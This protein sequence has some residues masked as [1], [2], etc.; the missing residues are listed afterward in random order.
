MW[1]S[2][3]LLCLAFVLPA[4]ASAQ[5]NSRE[6]A[7][8]RA[9]QLS[10]LGP[11]AARRIFFENNDP[12][13]LAARAI[14]SY[15]RGCLAGA[16][17]L[18]PDG[19]TW[20]VMR[21]TRQRNWGHP[22][23]I[24]WIE[25]FARDAHSEG[26]P[27]LLVGDIAQPRG[28]PMLTGHASHQLGLEAD[29]WLTPARTRLSSEEREEMPAIDM[30][31]RDLLSVYPDRFT[32]AHIKLLLRAA[33]Y[34]QVDRI[35]VNAAIKKAMCARTPPENR[36]WLAKIRPWHGHTFHFHVALHCPPGEESC[37]NKRATP[38]GEGCGADLQAWFRDSVRFP[39]PR[40][41][42]PGRELTL[43]DYPEA[44]RKVAVTR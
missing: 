11:D 7:A 4:A 15:G 43:A 1:R 12:A 39:K 44:C 33:S 3:I 42:A 35:F 26:W 16:Q 8:R 20:Q 19:P 27:G 40:T 34:P 14:G 41:G 17:A 23:L 5:E 10:R 38:Q 31:R 30:V 22:A 6:E 37:V 36:A 28:G 32:D 13:P 25:R 2:A 9:A 24:S 18:S 29:L 21:L